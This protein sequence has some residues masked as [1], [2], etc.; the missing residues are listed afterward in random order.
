MDLAAI[1]LIGDAT[2]QPAGDFRS[3]PCRGNMVAAMRAC[4]GAWIAHADF[5]AWL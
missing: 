5:G 3:A 2:P 1:R 4:V